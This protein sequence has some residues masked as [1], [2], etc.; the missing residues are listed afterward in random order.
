MSDDLRNTEAICKKSG[1]FETLG[2]GSLLS[3][4]DELDRLHAIACNSAD[5]YACMKHYGVQAEQADAARY[6]DALGE[7][8]SPFSEAARNQP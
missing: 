2:P 1:A 4:A 7:L 3:L 5:L 6:M 8:L